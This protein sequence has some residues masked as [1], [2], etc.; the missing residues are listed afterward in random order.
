MSSVAP[1]FVIVNNGRSGSTLLVDLLR[2]HPD[3]QCEGEIL[4]ERL[5]RRW[6][7]PLLG[8]IRA[9]PLPYLERWAGRA[10][11]PVYGFK[12]KT[13]GQVYNLAKTL[14]GL[15]NHGWRLIYLHRRN[16][17]QQTLSW[18]VAQASGRW[19]TTT[20]RPRTPRTVTLDV[21][22]FLHDL[23]TCVKDR[24]TLADLM[25]H[26]PHLPLVYE[27]NLQSSEQWPITSAR[28]CTWLGVAPV[29]LT[30][31]IVK[32]WD[33]PY[34]EVVTN[35]AE[36]MAA[37]ARSPFDYLFTSPTDATRITADGRGA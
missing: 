11:K 9:R 19:Q 36:I 8:L 37:V 4:N 3:I 35:Y 18:S 5:W 12:L 2:S 31:Q 28:V 14:R 25:R 6:R 21:D 15:Q 13:G 27:D 17:L 30:S 29:S 33:R 24:Q 26:L 32:T 20:D 1:R 10:T 23:R 16:A 22:D 34:A 7:R